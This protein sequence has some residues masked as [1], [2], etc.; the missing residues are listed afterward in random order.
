MH[1]ADARYSAA[2]PLCLGIEYDHGTV[3]QMGDD[4]Q[5]PARVETRIVQA[6]R[7]VIEWRIGQRL[8]LHR[9]GDVAGDGAGGHKQP[10]REVF[11]SR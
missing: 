6:R 7:V 5:V 2:D 4:Q 3:T 8:Q 9:L 11:S 10:G 1:L